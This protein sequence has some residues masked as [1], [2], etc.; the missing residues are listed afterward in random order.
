MRSQPALRLLCPKTPQTFSFWA[1]RPCLHTNA[2]STISSQPAPHCLCPR[3]RMFQLLH[4]CP[5]DQAS[6]TPK[7][8][9]SHHCPSREASQTPRV[10]LLHLCFRNKASQTF[11]SKNVH[12]WSRGASPT[13]VVQP[14]HS[15]LSREA[16]GTLRACFPPRLRPPWFCPN[17]DTTWPLLSPGQSLQ[18]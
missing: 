6:Q 7:S 15:C 5:S 10:H 9:P 16:L 1:P 14:R 13:S 17:Q 4:L 18:S 3:I 11:R 12:R 2:A 8:R